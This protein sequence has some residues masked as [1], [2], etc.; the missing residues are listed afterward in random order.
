MTERNA[1]YQVV[2]VGGGYAGV[3]AANRLRKRGDVG[4]TVVNPRG[5]FVDRIR[6]HQFVAGT[7]GAVID[8]GSLLG[9]GVRLVVD[10][11][12]GIDVGGRVVRL[13][14]GR[15]VGYDYLV[16][17]VGS[18]A[19]RA[20]VRGVEE[21]AYS[22]GEIEGA[23]RLRDRL[24]ELGVGEPVVVVG[25]GPT[26]IE[27]AA[28]LA[29]RGRGVTVVSGV[30]LMPSLSERGRR[31]VAKWL[32]RNGVEVAAGEVVEVRADSVVLADGGVLPSAVTVW[33]TG[34]GVPGLAADSG[35]RTDSIGRML[36][37][38]TLTSVDDDRIVATGDAAAPSG[39]PLRMSSQAAGALGARA[40]DTVLSRIAGTEPAV[41]D[42][43]LTGTCVS[44]GR[45]DGIR[46]LARKD[47]TAV[48]IYIGGWMGARIKEGTCKLGVWKM[49]REA[50]KPGSLFWPKGGPRPSIAAS[51]VISA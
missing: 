8:Y 43:A 45:R 47:D 10:T 37:D 32:S 1:G 33:A 28:E 13:G 30:G 48:N 25:G 39:Q 17:A 26:G 35:L 41:I 46:Q 38:E 12:T 3:V 11:A 15:E 44:L 16:Y 21:F 2:V 20:G 5:E 24:G 36:T 6:L 29:E 31:Y 18:T 9:E 40:A 51:K 27:V 50:R 49:R 23:R 7:G 14:S 19:G 42:L 4:I 34:F 22:V